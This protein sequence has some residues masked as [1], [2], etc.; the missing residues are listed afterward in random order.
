MIKLILDTYYVVDARVIEP[1]EKGTRTV[2]ALES[3]MIEN[4]LFVLCELENKERRW[5]WNH[6]LHPADIA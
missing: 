3:K 1:T 2:Y 5:I 6:Y 4:H